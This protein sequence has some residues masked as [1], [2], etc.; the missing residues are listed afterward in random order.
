MPSRHTARR[1]VPTKERAVRTIGET[2][3][4]EPTASVLPFGTGAEVNAR[5]QSSNPSARRAARARRRDFDQLVERIERRYADKPWRLRLRT[6][7]LVALGFAGFLFWFLLL[8][9]IGV[10][11][12]VLGVTLEGDQVFFLIALG[13]ILLT[14]GI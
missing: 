14:L 4:R 11:L 12:F 1:A 8:G 9:G 5:A 2:P 10:L 13:A 3:Q 7:L 6:A